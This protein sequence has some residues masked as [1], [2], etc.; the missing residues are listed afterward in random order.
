MQFD[1]LNLAGVDEMV[2][3]LGDSRSANM[4]DGGAHFYG[5]FACADGKH[6]ALGPLE[7]HF[8]KC[9]LDLCG[10][11]D[12]RFFE[13]MDPAQ[14]PALKQTLGD[15]F[16]TRTRD[17]WCE[18]LEGSDACF[19]PVLDMAEA[20]RH[21]HNVARNTFIQI[22]DVT[23][24]APA[25]RFSGTPT[26]TPTPPPAV[27]QHS[28]EILRDWQFSIDEIAQLLADQVVR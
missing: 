2:V 26:A 27:G 25:P 23:Q 4:V 10:I 14:W 21:P 3:V 7:P 11:T 8:Y 13:Q 16:R 17:Q 19:A 22:E 12:P 6:I 5:T 1:N 18:L 28:R 9:L 15:I 24:P 20:P